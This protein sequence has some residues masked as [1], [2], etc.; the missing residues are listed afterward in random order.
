MDLGVEGWCDEL[1]GADAWFRSGADTV[2][3]AL[4]AHHTFS[5]RLLNVGGFL[6]SGAPF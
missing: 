1:S 6:D 5:W 2:S 4:L 3:G